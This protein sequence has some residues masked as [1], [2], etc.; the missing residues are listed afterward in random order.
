LSELHARVSPANTE[1]ARKGLSDPDPMVR[2]AALEMLDGLPGDRVWTLVSPLLSDPSRGVRIT[3]ASV[4]AVVPT[5]RQPSSDRKAFD[6]AA[7]EFIAAQRFN[8][9]RPEARSTLGNFFVRRG[10]T[11]EAEN[12]YKAG[13]QLSPQYAPA[14]INLADLFRQLHRDDD[15]QNVL[16]TALAFSPKDAGLHH[17]LGLTLTRQKRPDD[18]LVEF[19][20]ATELE[21]DRSRYAYVYAVALHSLGR[22]DESLNVLKENLAR[23]A[24]DRDTLLALVTFNRDAGNIGSALD[25]AEQLSRAAP[26]DHEVTRLTD[27]LR[28]RLQR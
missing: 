8:A 9:D 16:R 27:E 17:A 15:A 11:T 2:N 4:L 22:V 19:L 7:D 18:A 6:R 1:L 10:L 26:N 28:A 20:A 21:P 23:H 13:L 3:A 5:A 25:Y 14:A 24:D 12:E